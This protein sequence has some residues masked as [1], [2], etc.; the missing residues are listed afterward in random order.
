MVICKKIWAP[1]LCPEFFQFCILFEN[2]MCHIHMLAFRALRRYFS[3][4]GVCVDILHFQGSFYTQ[5][6]WHHGS[7]T[8]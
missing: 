7:V 4:V 5:I 6:L 2:K 1:Y 8:R 3:L